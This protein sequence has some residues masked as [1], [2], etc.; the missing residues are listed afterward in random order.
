MWDG[1]VLSRR[2][3]VEPGAHSG[4]PQTASFSDGL[5]SRSRPARA[6]AS[7]RCQPAAPIIAALSVQSPGRGTTSGIAQRRR[8]A[9]DPLPQDGVRRHAPHPG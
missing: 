4:R 1:L 9:G 3:R 8:A 7:N 6:P 2:S 5:A